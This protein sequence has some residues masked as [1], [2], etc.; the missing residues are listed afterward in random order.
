MMTDTEVL[1]WIEYNRADIQYS[2]G[3]WYTEE[4][5]LVDLPFRA[6]SG[7]TAGPP[8]ATVRE[9]VQSLHDA[10]EKEWYRKE[11]S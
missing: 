4:G 2:R 10:L 3:Q 5:E 6:I 1:D 11:F 8:S 9:A 7:G